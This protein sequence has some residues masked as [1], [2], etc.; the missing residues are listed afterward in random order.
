MSA[1]SSL[2]EVDSTFSPL[3]FRLADDISN[4]VIDVWDWRVYCW[5]NENDKRTA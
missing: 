5:Q 1:L 4:D 2:F 3:S